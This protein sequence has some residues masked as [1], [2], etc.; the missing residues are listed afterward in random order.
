MSQTDIEKCAIY[1]RT[2]DRCSISCKLGLWEVEGPYGL[3]LMNEA[4]HYFEQYRADGE[5]HKILG[6]ESPADILMR[7]LER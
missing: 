6:G 1:K 7:S 2:G 3:A 5:Y 4:D